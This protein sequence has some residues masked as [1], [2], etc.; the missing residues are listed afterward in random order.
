MQDKPKQKKGGAVSAVSRA[1]LNPA[2]KKGTGEQT[3]LMMVRMPKSLLARVQK[4]AKAK[5][6]PASSYVRLLIEQD[7]E[8]PLE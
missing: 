6:M 4:R 2:N 8:K 1:N 7:T 5:R 3:A